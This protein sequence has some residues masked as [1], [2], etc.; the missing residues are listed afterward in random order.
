MV[1][2]QLDASWLPLGAAAADALAAITRARQPP[3]AAD[4]PPVKD[5]TMGTFTATNP[6]MIRKGTLIGSVDLAMPSGLR[7]RGLMLFESHGRRW[8]NFPSIPWTKSDGSKSYVPVLEFESRQISDRFGAAVVPIC[9][10]ALG[11]APLAPGDD[12]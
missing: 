5:T 1:A 12:R 3:A 6:K 8:V 9:E 10:A 2:R 4:P 7:V 11:L